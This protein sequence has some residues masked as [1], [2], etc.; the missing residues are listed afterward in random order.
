MLFLSSLFCPF[1][2]SV[3]ALISHNLFLSFPFLFPFSFSPSGGLHGPFWRPWPCE[4]PYCWVTNCCSQAAGPPLAPQWGHCPP[5]TPK[6]SRILY[7]GLSPAAG[8]C[9]SGRDG[10]SSWVS[11][12]TDYGAQFLCTDTR[13]MLE[14]QLYWLELVQLIIYCWGTGT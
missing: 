1:P 6:G 3:C 13:S 14:Q 8:R 11:S 7:G 9:C 5:P 2:S 12:S 10:F 4:V